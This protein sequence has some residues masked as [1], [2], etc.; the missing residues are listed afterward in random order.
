[1]HVRGPVV[2]VLLLLLERRELSRRRHEKS[3]GP[4]HGSQ[5]QGRSEQRVHVLTRHPVDCVVV[6]V[7]VLGRASTHT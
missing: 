3:L 7:V 1:M 5:E 4:A 2:L 6:F